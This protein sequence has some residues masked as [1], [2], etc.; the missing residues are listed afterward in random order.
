M[1]QK[2]SWPV[3]EATGSR[4]AKERPELFW[5]QASFPVPSALTANFLLL[6][7]SKDK[8]GLFKLRSDTGPTGLSSI[9]AHSANKNLRI[10]AW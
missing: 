5:P 6:H 2:Q 8:I 4:Q 9:F 10:D 3:L 7:V 1:T